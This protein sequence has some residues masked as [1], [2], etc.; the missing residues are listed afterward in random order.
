MN[1]CFFLNS[2]YFLINKDDSVVFFGSLFTGKNPVTYSES[3]K[4]RDII[5][6]SKCI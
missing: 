4:I 6:P 2:Y 3:I 1:S 5:R